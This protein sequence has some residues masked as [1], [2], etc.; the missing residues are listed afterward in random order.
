VETASVN[1]KP[2]TSVIWKF[3]GFEVEK[4]ERILVADKRKWRA[5]TR[6]QCKIL[7]AQATYISISENIIEFNIK[8]QQR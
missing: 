5:V 4:N 3:F 1:L 2:A 8:Q 7:G 6:N